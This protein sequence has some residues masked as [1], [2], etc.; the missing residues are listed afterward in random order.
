MESSLERDHFVRAFARRLTLLMQDADLVS[1]KSKTGVKVSK[2]AETAGCSKQMARRYV[3]GDALPEIDAT[4]KIAK[5]LNVSPGWLLFGDETAIPNNMAQVNLIQIEPDLLQY[6]LTKAA[7]LFDL[8]TDTKE[9]VHFIMDIINDATHIEAERK[10]ILKVI[11]LSI[12]SAARF[13]GI[14]NDKQVRA[15]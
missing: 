13:N 7:F 1:F 2:L 15:G 3:L 8:T 5:W 10:D 12:N 11:D 9:L 14:K 4:Y 6:I